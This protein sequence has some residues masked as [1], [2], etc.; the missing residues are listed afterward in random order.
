LAI[1]LWNDLAMT[2]LKA[3]GRALGSGLLMTAAA[4][5]DMFILTQITNSNLSIAEQ[6]LLMGVVTVILWMVIR[7]I[8]QL[9]TM[10]TAMPEMIGMQAMSPES[11]ILRRNLRRLTRQQKHTRKTEGNLLDWLSERGSPYDSD[12]GPRT[13]PE[14]VED[15]V[16]A[17]ATRRRSRSHGRGRPDAIGVV[18]AGLPPGTGG[19]D[20]SGSRGRGSGTPGSGSGGGGAAASL[21]SGRHALPTAEDPADPPSRRSDIEPS[22]DHPTTNN[23]ERRTFSGTAS[24]DIIVPSNWERDEGSADRWRR[25]EAD[26]SKA[27]SDDLPP[28]RPRLHEGKEIYE[29]YRPGDG[30]VVDGRR[31]EAEDDGER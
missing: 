23:P 18:Y 7:P 6:L 13:R 24:G 22:T 16:Y 12:D 3:A 21:P 30:S 14:G 9:R 25:A 27:P 10:L 11:R 1:I 2:I 31:P 4:L 8:R 15:V 29:I 19:G 17:T 26:E 5:V 20:S 28:T